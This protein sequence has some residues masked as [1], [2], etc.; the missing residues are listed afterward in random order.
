MNQSIRLMDQLQLVTSADTQDQLI[1]ALTESANIL[2]FEY[3]AFGL[4]APFPL[5]SPKIQMVN[6]Y[7][8]NWQKKYI[9]NNYLSVD[10]IVNH[11]KLSNAPIIWDE[12]AFSDAMPFWEDARSFGVQYGWAQASRTPIGEIGMLT[13]SRSGDKLTEKELCSIQP[14]LSWLAQLSFSGFSKYCA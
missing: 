13:L 10:P 12:K 3:F 14:F 8:I 1:L 4:Q 9:D 6:N 7:P 11:G 5:P 2:G